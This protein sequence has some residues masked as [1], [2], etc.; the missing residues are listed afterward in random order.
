METKLAR[1]GNSDH[2][3]VRVYLNWDKQTSPRPSDA[4]ASNTSDIGGCI[5]SASSDYMSTDS[6][7]ECDLRSDTYDNDIPPMRARIA[8]RV[9]PSGQSANSD[10]LEMIEIPLMR[11]ASYVNVCQA[12]CNIVVASGMSLSIFNFDKK[13][14]ES[15]KREFIDFD[16]IMEVDIGFPILEVSLLE[17]VIGCVSERE[18][19]V[20]QIVTNGAYY[21]K[22]KQCG[23]YP[24][25]SNLV[26]NPAVSVL[27]EMGTWRVGDQSGPFSSLSS[28]SNKPDVGSPRSGSSSRSHSRSKSRSK[29]RSPGGRLPG[30]RCDS[31]EG[32]NSRVVGLREVRQCIT[33]PEARDYP[34]G[35]FLCRILFLLFS[36]VSVW[37]NALHER[38]IFYRHN[39]CI[40][41][42]CVNK[43]LFDQSAIKLIS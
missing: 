2:T 36:C 4:N 34:R 11:P 7:Q 24:L 31:D 26:K 14:L 23:H 35:S 5:S 12:T 3:Y 43:K 39:E 27:R 21:N 1:S 13:V 10:T 37:D 41:F 17:D 9:T 33:T 19:H 15:P 25:K 28:Q 38:H 16:E 42:H 20:F 32:H 18:V 40:F 6:T 30:G 8:G 29:S 22:Q